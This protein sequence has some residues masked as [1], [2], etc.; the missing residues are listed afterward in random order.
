MP[1]GNDGRRVLV[2]EPFEVLR[3]FDGVGECSG[4][5]PDDRHRRGRNGAGTALRGSRHPSGGG[6]AMGNG[7]ERH[8]VKGG[9]DLS[10]MSRPMFTFP[11][12][13]AHCRFL[14]SEPQPRLRAGDE[15]F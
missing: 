1:E 14:L 2:D 4:E 5:R 7:Q 3:P 11:S 6:W 8:S 10:D 9:C 15:G 13:I 12:P